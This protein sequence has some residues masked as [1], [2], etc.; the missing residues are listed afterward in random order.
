MQACHKAKNAEIQKSTKR[1]V[2]RV[3]SE[4]TQDHVCEMPTIS[5]EEAKE[6]AFVPSALCEPR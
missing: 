4:E 6:C 3:E 5:T 2:I 1:K